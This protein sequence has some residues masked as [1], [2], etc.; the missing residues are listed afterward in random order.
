MNNAGWP[1]L[2]ILNHQNIQI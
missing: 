2:K 1:L